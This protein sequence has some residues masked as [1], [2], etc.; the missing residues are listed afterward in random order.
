MTVGGVLG[1]LRTAQRY[2][3]P[4][5]RPFCVFSLFNGPIAPP[6]ISRATGPSSPYDLGSRQRRG[7][8][9]MEMRTEAALSGMSQS[10][11]E[12]NRR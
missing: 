3:R 9:R 2:G 1:W 10:L 12:F 7:G 4:S 5:G 6:C 8:L 11:G